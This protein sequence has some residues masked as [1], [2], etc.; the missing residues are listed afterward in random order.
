MLDIN[1]VADYVKLPIDEII[2]WKRVSQKTGLQD[3]FIDQ[4]AD[5]LDWEIMSL[6][7][8]FPPWIV[9]K[10]SDKI[11][12]YN[13][14]QNKNLPTETVLACIDKLDL[15][16]SIENH[17]YT[18]DMI[19]NFSSV[20]DIPMILI[21]QVV[22]T[23]T[24]KQLFQNRIDYIELVLQFQTVD[25]TFLDWIISR[26]K[27]DNCEYFDRT[28]VLDNQHHL[29]T[30]WVLDN[31]IKD[32]KDLMKYAIS[33]F[34]LPDIEVLRYFVSQNDI[35]EFLEALT[36]QKLREPLL[37]YFLEVKKDHRQQVLKH[38]VKYQQFTSEFLTYTSSSCTKEEQQNLNMIAFLRNFTYYGVRELNWSEED[39]LKLIKNLD[40]MKLAITNLS[41]CEEFVNYAIENISKFPW[42]TFL[43]TNEITPGQLVELQKSKLLHPLELWFAIFKNTFSFE[44]MKSYR[45]WWEFM[46]DEQIQNLSSNVTDVNLH[47]CLRTFIANTDWNKLLLEEQLPEWLIEIFGNHCDLI[48]P[49]M[50]GISYWWKIG[51][52]MSLSDGFIDKYLDRLGLENIIRHQY[53]TV[54]RYNRIKPF[55]GDPEL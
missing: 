38:I 35:E 31:I 9:E 3:H 13:L 6:V 27:I 41:G 52:Y 30:E 45:R 10:Y 16:L 53:L 39:V 11:D 42:F 4:N 8:A 40:L 36:I 23:S 17:K 50:N 19:L 5:Y 32:N 55:L 54:D 14:S 22:S 51:R 25:E 48:E 47:T 7:Q 49:R 28:D 18:D 29:S 26:E 24:I 33:N 37:Y 34:P 1:E 12:F 46:N 44:S 43:A 15:D 20:I 2:N 21:H